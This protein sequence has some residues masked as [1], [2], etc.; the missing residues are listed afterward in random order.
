[1]TESMLRV[2]DADQQRAFV[3][4]LANQTVTPWSDAPLYA[5]VHR[6]AQTLA[7][8]CARLGYRLAHIDQCYRL[9]RV[10][11]DATVAVPVG[12]PPS[13]FELLLTLYAAACLDDRR[14]DS[15]TL[16]DLSDD[17]HLSTASVGGPPYDP[18]LRSHRQ[19]LVSAVDRLVAH[20]VLERRTDDRLI[21]EWERGAEGIGAGLVLHRDAL[22]LLI[23]TDDVDL[24]LAGRGHSAEDSRGARLLRQLVETQGILVD[25]LPEDEQQY[26]WGQRTRLASLA[27]EMTG[28]T[29]EIRS[30]LIL[31]VLPADRE[32]PASVYLDFPSATARDWVALRLLDDVARVTDGGTPTCPQ[33][34]VAGLAR[35]LHASQGR[36]LT[37]AMQDLPDLVLSAAEARLRDLGLLRVQPD[38]AWQLTPL[39]GRFRGADLAQPAAAPTPLFPEDR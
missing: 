26:L 21:E 14:E 5:L 38:G 13:R 7:T 8:W 24:A 22:T 30:D 31:L 23:S 9:R 10:P 32:L 29:V 35:E 15:V 1:M 27:G 4:L 18:N 12:D 28:G 36:Y 16:Q 3:G 17:V 33:D 6:H 19:E 2:Y 34:R 39:A 25:E 11:I 20:G 37:K